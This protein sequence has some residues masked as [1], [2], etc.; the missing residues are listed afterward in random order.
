MDR[1]EPT[2]YHKVA[3]FFRDVAEMHLSVDAVCHGTAPGEVYVN[4][5]DRPTVGFVTTPEGEYL[6]GDAACESAYPGLRA[7][8]PERAYLILHP[9]SWEQVLTRIWTNPVARRHRRLHLRWQRP[10]A[11]QARAELP[12]GFELVAIDREFLARTEL[13]NHEEITNRA[14]D[15][16]SIDSFLQQ[17]FGYCVIG[18]NAVVS[19]CVSDCVL[20]DK[21]EIG[22][23]TDPRYRR[24]GLAFA[25]VAATIQHCLA[26]GLTHIGWHCLRSNTG[27]RS[28]AEKAG[29]EVMAEYAAFSAVL[30]SEN[31]TDLTPEEYADWALHYEKHAALNDVYRLFAVEAWT[32]AGEFNRALD[33]LQLLVRD[34]WPGRADWLSH[35]WALQGLRDLPEYLSIISAMADRSDRDE[36]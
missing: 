5:L 3:P 29:F 10:D 25:A 22:V 21:C 34:R 11:L 28:L 16:P 24:R 17:G 36:A 35:R 13:R 31:A 18:D 7:L 6:V 23:G 26:R 14:K 32:L 27:S 15:W 20:G 12:V 9:V 33:Q 19:R 2:H 8:I 1:V 30:P 4:S